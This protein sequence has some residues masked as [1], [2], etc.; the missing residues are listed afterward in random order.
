MATF[1]YDD[2]TVRLIPREG[3][4]FA[5]HAIVDGTAC[6]GRLRLPLD[7]LGL[8]RAVVEVARSRDIG[9]T[10]GAAVPAVQLGGVLAD[11]LFDGAIGEAYG[12][13]LRRAREAVVVFV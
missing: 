13:L 10:P 8:E 1:V 3:D 2:F 9:A 6:D 7:R 4:G 5:V 12:V 11:A